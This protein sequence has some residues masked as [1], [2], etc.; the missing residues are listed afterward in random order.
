MRIILALLL[1][2]LVSEAWA[3]EDIIKLKCID[4]ASF[5]EE[6]GITDL[7]QIM[8]RK[9]DQAIRITHYEPEKK[10]QGLVGEYYWTE[11]IPSLPN[12]EASEVPFLLPVKRSKNLV[13]YDELYA[14]PDDDPRRYISRYLMVLDLEKQVISIQVLE[15]DLAETYD[16]SGPKDLASII[17]SGKT[18]PLFTPRLRVKEGQLDC[19]IPIEY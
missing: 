4:E 8:L 6:S 17:V 3:A 15:S 12:S 10:K 2:G 18:M 16:D 11:L 5:D 1:I 9:S 7:Y 14:E 13:L 19:K